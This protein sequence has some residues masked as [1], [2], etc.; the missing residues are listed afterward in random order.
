MDTKKTPQGDNTKN[1]NN[2]GYK[3]GPDILIQIL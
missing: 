2:H 3:L 1:I